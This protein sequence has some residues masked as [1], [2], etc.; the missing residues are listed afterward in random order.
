MMRKKKELLY[1]ILPP[2]PGVYIMKDSRGRVLYVGKAANLRRRVASYFSHARLGRN[3]GRQAHDPRIER[4]MRVVARVD[5]RKTDTVLEALILE[6]RLI[7]KLSPPYNIREK[8]D[9]SFLYVQITEE[10]FPRVLLVRGKELTERRRGKVYGPFTSASSIREAMRIIRRIFPWNTHGGKIKEGRREKRDKKPCFDYQ[11]GFCPGT[12]IGA[13]SR[14]EYLKNIKHIK[15]FFEG[16]KKTLLASLAR[17]MRQASRALEFEKAATIRK[18]LFALAHIQDVALLGDTSLSSLPPSLSSFRIEGYDI[19]N[20]SG[21]SAVGSMVVFLNGAPAKSEYRKF[22]IR[23]ITQSDDVGMLQEVLRRR[24]KHAQPDG[25]WQLPDLILVDGGKAQVNAV[26]RVVEEFGF[27]LPVVG[28]AKG[29]KRK[30][31]DLVGRLPKGVTLATLIRVRDEA[32]RFAISY[33]KKVRGRKF[34]MRG[35]RQ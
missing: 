15:L 20:I 34:L 30:R 27:E 11:L 23:T 32:H 9:K 17:E 1:R 13:V 29:L 31:N 21:T 8:D 33:H 12:C 14:R 7:K 19:S 26:E 28:L 16:K 10:K 24:L 35:Y 2:T 18:Q 4:L 3:F 5:H 22:E 6:T 25:T